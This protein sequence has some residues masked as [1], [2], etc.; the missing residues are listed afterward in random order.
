MV[1]QA[2]KDL[3]FGSKYGIGE[4]IDQDFSRDVNNL[5]SKILSKYGNPGAH[6]PKDI[7]GFWEIFQTVA[8]TKAEQEGTGGTLLIVEGFPTDIR[9]KTWQEIITFG[10]SSRMP[11][12][13][14]RHSPF[15]RPSRYQMQP[16]PVNVGEDETMPGY[17]LT[18]YQRWVDNYITITPWSLTNAEANRRAM[19][20]ENLLCD[21]REYFQ[22]MGVNEI[23]WMGQDEDVVHVPNESGDIYHGRPIQAFVRTQKTWVVRERMLEEV[24]VSIRADFDIDNTGD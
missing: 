2:D 9:D 14:N 10:V 17:S 22:F 1:S 21:F 19:W 18:T 15:E 5:F 20:V 11:G 3:I 23:L 12:G 24:L 4:T 13:T 7:L 16:T 6:G 8:S